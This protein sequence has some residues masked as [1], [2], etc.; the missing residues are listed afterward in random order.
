MANGY[1]AEWISEYP[2]V[3]DVIR[4]HPHM[5]AFY[6]RTP[7]PRAEKRYREVGDEQWAQVLL[8]I[9]R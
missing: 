6:Q 4:T 1:L 3:L 2:T 5:E 7:L 8:E 9:S